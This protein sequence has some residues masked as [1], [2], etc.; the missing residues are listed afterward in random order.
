M[1]EVYLNKPENPTAVATQ[2]SFRRG[3]GGEQATNAVKGNVN[4]FCYGILI[5][6]VFSNPKA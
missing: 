6:H 2:C 5:F 3:V 4:A 1:A